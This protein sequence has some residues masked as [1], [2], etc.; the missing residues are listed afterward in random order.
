MVGWLS[1]QIK[2][3]NYTK[4]EK[5]EKKLWEK[6]KQW[7]KMR[8]LRQR[9][10]RE[11]MGESCNRWEMERWL[12]QLEW[13]QTEG[14]PLFLTYFYLIFFFWVHQQLCWRL[15]L[16]P[17]GVKSMIE[18]RLIY[19]LNPNAYAF[20]VDIFFLVPQCILQLPSPP[21]HAWRMPLK[22]CLYTI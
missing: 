18:A 13:K 20:W 8:G 14:F 4:Q 16:N 15:C 1:T 10:E 2:G 7:K 9:N 22:I 19:A 5:Q 17:Q 6:P 11:A 21:K 12:P 3:E